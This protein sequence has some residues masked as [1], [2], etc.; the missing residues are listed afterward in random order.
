[1]GKEKVKRYKVALE[2]WEKSRLVGG[3]F[4]ASKGIQKT[5]AR[6]ERMG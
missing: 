3:K 6:K 2:P 5:I 4:K 1:V